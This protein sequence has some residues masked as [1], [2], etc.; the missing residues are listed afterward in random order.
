MVGYNSGPVSSLNRRYRNRGISFSRQLGNAFSLVVVNFTNQEQT[1][2]FTFPAGGNYI[3]QIEG[4]RNLAG[5]VAGV[6]QTLSVP[7]NY[8]CIWTQ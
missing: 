2:S 1:A 8:G 3:E 4:A 5:V 6:A 7:S